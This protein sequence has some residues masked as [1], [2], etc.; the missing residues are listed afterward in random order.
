MPPNFKSLNWAAFLNNFN[1]AL[2]SY[3]KKRF[4]SRN[5]DLWK[6]IKERAF[7]DL[8]REESAQNFL[9]YDPEV[10]KYS[11]DIIYVDNRPSITRSTNQKEDIKVILQ[12]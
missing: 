10:K 12:F 9:N 7:L 6:E 8:V 2:L 1:D 11:G 5:F 4:K 3:S